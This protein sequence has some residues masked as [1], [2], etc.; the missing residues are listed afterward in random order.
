MPK[1]RKFQNRKKKKKKHVP[2]PPPLEFPVGSAEY[3]RV[4]NLE[5]EQ[6]LQEKFLLKSPPTDSK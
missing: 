2:P 4:R 1:F 3:V 6:R 5:S